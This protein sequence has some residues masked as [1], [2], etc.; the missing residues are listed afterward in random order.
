MADLV[1]SADPEPSLVVCDGVPMLDQERTRAMDDFCNRMLENDC[2][3]VVTCTPSSDTFSHLQKDALHLNGA[4]LL[5]TDDELRLIAFSRHMDDEAIC[6]LNDAERIPFL[7]WR[8]EGTCDFVKLL[9]AEDLPAEVRLVVFVMFALGEGV[10]DDAYMFL[11]TERCNDIFELL[12]ADYPFV[13]VDLC[14]RRYRSIDISIAALVKGFGKDLNRIIQIIF[15]DNRDAFVK[16]L[17]DML[18][19]R[20]DAAR[21][22][23]LIS[24]LATDKTGLSWI[25]KNHRRIA[26]GG[27]PLSILRMIGK[28]RR[29]VEI[30]SDSIFVCKMRS[31]AMLGDNKLCI[32]AA[33]GLINSATAS[34]SQKLAAW[35]YMISIDADNNSSADIE[36]VSSLAAK[37]RSDI[38]KVDLAGCF[39]SD[40]FASVCAAYANGVKEA[41]ETWV[42]I[43]ESNCFESPRSKRDALLMSA[44]WIMD[45]T[46]NKVMLEERGKDAQ[47]ECLSLIQTD[48]TVFV[49]LIK[50]C[51]SQIKE[52]IDSDISD[53]IAAYTAIRLEKFCSALPEFAEYLPDSDMK[54]YAYRLKSR[55]DAQRVR[56]AE[57]SNSASSAKILAKSQ[58]PERSDAASSNSTQSMGYPILKVNLFGGLEIHIGSKSVSL[59]TFK[60]SK[61]KE[62]LELMVINRGREMQRSRIIDLL[63]PEVDI[64]AGI[65]NFYSVW[66]ILRRA[67]RIDGECP[68]I[69]RTQTGCAMDRSLFTSDLYSY[70]E[71]CR[72]LIFG[73]EDPADWQMLYSAVCNDYPDKLLPTEIQNA[74]INSQREYYHAQMI[75]GLIATSS[76]LIDSHENQGALWFAREA[77]RR[78]KRREDVYIALME[79][80]IECNQRSQ[81][82]E[83]YFACREFLREELG[84]DP[85]PRLVELYRSIIEVEDLI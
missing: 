55:L 41:L 40:V 60:R 66:A 11:S 49:E 68:Y 37:V 73:N 82:L 51:L 83:T 29:G 69:F 78:E 20:E 7:I 71:L 80:Q 59:S 15:E 21:A 45:K 75:D 61:A 6:Q 67:I 70:E 65:K 62:L 85:S 46:S 30:S 76:R 42:E 50:F 32:Q 79:A 4:D 2:E 77:M 19:T 34:D 44:G 28:R 26:I 9:A 52:V 35:S 43:Y 16:R 81:A 5:L 8:E 25:S 31:A 48:N 1:I 3:V 14:S 39:D 58:S 10:L 24:R 63:W 53:A 22:C 57:F 38:S 54:R 23:E 72:T 13:G 17:A 18:L 56:Y 12:A 36:K 47:N 27:E 84:I 64:D 33:K 74:A